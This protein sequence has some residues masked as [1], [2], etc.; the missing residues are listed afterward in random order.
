MRGDLEAFAG[1]SAD[2]QAFVD[3]TS[4]TSIVDIPRV[5]PD[6]AQKW[7]RTVTAALNAPR[8]G[9]R[10]LRADV[11]HDVDLSSLKIIIIGSPGD[12]LKLLGLVQVW[13]VQLRP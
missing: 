9:G 2:T 12:T 13:S 8:P 4:V 10:Q 5:E 11:I 1:I 3:D 6:L 7:A